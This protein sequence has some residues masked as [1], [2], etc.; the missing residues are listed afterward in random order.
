MSESILVSIKKL[1][2]LPEEEE[3]FDVDVIV[4][5]NTNLSI[6]H[7]LGVGPDTGVFITDASTLWS[8]I[9]GS[10]PR[11]NDVKT[12]VFLKTKLVFDPPTTSF[13]LEST[14]KVIDELGWR[15]REYMESTQ[16]VPPATIGEEVT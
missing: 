4:H 14:Q 12:W 11:L 2:G 7:Q 9:I 13:H 15:I 10:D 6:L 1:L 16:W 5:I 3:E 8:D